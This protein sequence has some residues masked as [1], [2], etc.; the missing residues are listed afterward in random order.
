MGSVN[1]PLGTA[2]PPQA[3]HCLHGF[4]VSPRRSPAL[5]EG[6]RS[7]EA[8][9]NSSSAASALGLS[10][11]PQCGGRDQRAGQHL[12]P[13]ARECQKTR[14]RPR[15]L[16]PHDAGRLDLNAKVALSPGCVWRGS[17]FA[18]VLFSHLP[19]SSFRAYLGCGERV[20]S[21][22]HAASKDTGWQ[23]G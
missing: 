21:S 11:K 18:W 2:A 16:C 10:N 6:E 4:K 20:G 8:S 9:S 7:S 14:L 3:R 19:F 13:V 15:S 23:G 5:A 12:V 22:V 17:G 1:C